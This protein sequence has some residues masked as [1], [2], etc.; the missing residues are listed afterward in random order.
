M[1]RKVLIANRGEIAVRLIR[2]CRELGVATALACSE[3]DR[4][5]L[6]AR[7]ADEVVVIGPAHPRD[8]YLR[9]E[10]VVDAA[11]SC[12]A[13]AVHPGYGF[14]AERPEL[15]DACRRAGITFVGPSPESMRLL[16]EKT[17]AKT[18][19]ERLGVPTVP[20]YHGDDQSDERL[21]READ[22]VGFPLLV[23]AAAGGGGRGV[24]LVRT[25]AELPDALASARR[26]A[27][28]AFGDGRLLL[29]RLIAPARHVEVQAVA[30]AHGHVVHLGEREC[31]IQRRHQKLVEEAPSPAVDER[32]R[33]QL[34]EAAT[35][36]VRAAGYLGVATV[37]FLLD[38]DGSFFFLEVNPRLQVEHPVTELVTGV[39]LVHLQ[40]QIAAGAPLPF[41]QRDVALRGHAVEVRL[42]AE[43]P[44]QDFRPA[45]GR[46][47]AFA[48][49]TIEGV[50]HDVGVAPGDE[51]TP[52][53]DPLLG[54]L[55][56]WGA[57]RE[58]A[59]RRALA[60]LRA[61]EVE[62]VPTNL[63][64]LEA[65]LD[66]PRFADGALSTDFLD[67]HVTGGEWRPPRLPPEVLVGAAAF[68]IAD[69]TGGT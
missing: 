42:Y 67:S 2:A 27:E 66:H 49:P 52:F 36:V 68:E 65:V 48:P 32:L 26:E 3:A 51:V 15:S 57:T 47:T 43:D 31:S 61:Y 54:K 50:R 56:A 17:A 7:L 1:F 44:W 58:Q 23:K 11:R 25:A 16:G 39:D 20:G 13:D 8:S 18:L 40:L 69:R 45:V 10:A 64:L 21:I 46:L 6:P 22:V 28:A 34:G 24:R 53:Y 33:R 37:E 19:A 30:D 29:E 63:S 41:G 4:G 60:A 55:I 35:T 12:G 9:V 14:L 59:R 38:P 5:A 62:G